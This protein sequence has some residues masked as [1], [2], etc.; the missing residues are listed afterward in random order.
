MFLSGRSSPEKTNGR[1]LCPKCRAPMWNVRSDK[2]AD[3]KIF[4]CPRC[5]VIVLEAPAGRKRA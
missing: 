1:P 5:E 2:A 3:D 4:Q